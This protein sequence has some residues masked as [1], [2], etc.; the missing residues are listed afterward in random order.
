MAGRVGCRIY[1][2]D[3]THGLSLWIQFC[4]VGFIKAIIKWG[5]DPIISSNSYNLSLFKCTL[6]C[7]LFKGI[8]YLYK[9]L[10][11]RLAHGWWWVSVGWMNAFKTVTGLTQSQ[12]SCCIYFVFLNPAVKFWSAFSGLRAERKNTA[13][14]VESA[15]PRGICFWHSHH[16]SRPG[17]YGSRVM[18]Y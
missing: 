6:E 7:E 2:P 8:S 17:L 4:L 9:A 14:W 18:V 15:P 1:V 12:K 5:T 11:Q 13:W 3:S 16:K 10:T